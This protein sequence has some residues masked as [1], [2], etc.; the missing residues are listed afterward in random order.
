MPLPS[1]FFIKLGKIILVIILLLQFTSKASSHILEDGREVG[2]LDT[3]VD[4]LKE[5]VSGRYQSQTQPRD[6]NLMDFY[7]RTGNDFYSTVLSCTYRGTDCSDFEGNWK[8]VFTRYG[9]CLTFN[10][11]DDPSKV[12]QTLKGQFQSKQ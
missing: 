3:F 9:K 11:P 4:N 8:V 1:L 6:F 7:N 5:V 2:L 12:L 10:N